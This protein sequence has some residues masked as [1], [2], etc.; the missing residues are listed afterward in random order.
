MVLVL[1]K[2]ADIIF[3]SW[4]NQSD[5]PYGLLLAVKRNITALLLRTDIRRT[6]AESK[7]GHG[8]SQRCQVLEALGEEPDIDIVTT[9]SFV[10][11]D[12]H[13]PEFLIALP[14]QMDQLL[15][16][17]LHAQGLGSFTRSVL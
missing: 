16:A 4:F 9:I 12:R 11:T 8:L 17:H 13:S 1:D 7:Q 10:S 5:K 14:H 15:P 6:F 3:L 2:F